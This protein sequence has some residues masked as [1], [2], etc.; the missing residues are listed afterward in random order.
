[1]SSKL[2]RTVIAIGLISIF[3]PLLLL[4]GCGKSNNSVS[5]DIKDKKSLKIGLPGGYSVT[6]KELLDL[7]EKKNPDISLI[8]D[9]AP[10]GDYAKRVQTQLMSD[11]APDAWFIESG[12]VIS[13]GAMGVVEDLQPYISKEFNHDD[14]WVLDDAKDQEGHIWGIPH[15]LQSTALAYNRNY[16][17]DAGMEYP[18]G[19]WNFDELIL[20]AQKLTS[21]DNDGNTKRYGILLNTSI[22]VSWFPWIRGLGGKVLDESRSRSMLNSPQTIAA[23][24]KWYSLQEKGIIPSIPVSQANQGAISMFGTGKGAMNFLLYNECNQLNDNFQDL[25]WDVG[26]IPIGTNGQRYVPYVANAWVIN[27]KASKES[28]EL[29]WRWLKFWLSDEAQSILGR[30]GSNLPI[31]KKV[32]IRGTKQQVPAHREVFVNYLDEAGG[33]LDINPTWNAWRL[34]VSSIIKD[35]W[36]EKISVKLGMEQAHN[37]VEDILRKGI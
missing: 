15:G 22:T 12:I 6:P 1:M 18:N 36:N 24:E 13:Y 27:K 29:A 7:F 14:Y 11:K 19:K 31:N 16:F 35:I 33:N 8:V 21:K 4:A 28:K 30:D 10:W 17:D 26:P 32:F 25:E 37:E 23:V 34:A 20:A 5:K 2:K 3:V 9:D